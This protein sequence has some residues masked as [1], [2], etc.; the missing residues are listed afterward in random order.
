MENTCKNT[1]DAEVLET[2]YTYNEWLKEYKRRT[3]IL[4]KAKSVRI[5][6]D[7]DRNYCADRL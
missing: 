4:R 6:I 3:C 1:Y 5:G 7:N 2:V